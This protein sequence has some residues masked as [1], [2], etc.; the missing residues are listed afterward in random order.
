MSSLSDK[1]G[2]QEAV[3]GK[4]YT[5]LQADQLIAFAYALQTPE[6]APRSK[7]WRKVRS[8]FVRAHPSCAACGA[9]D[10]LEAHHMKP[11]HLYP[12]L[13]LDPGNLITLCQ[14][15]ARLCHF[16]VGHC[17]DWKAYNPNV[18]EHA[19]RDLEMLKGRLAA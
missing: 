13:E 16:R 6:Y 11:Y 5:P 18:T 14:S 10:T 15:P 7:K 1:S 19:A 3:V 9:S 17:Y 8:D 12:D 4:L 2:G